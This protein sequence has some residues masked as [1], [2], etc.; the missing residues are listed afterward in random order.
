MA[1]VVKDRARK[2]VAQARKRALDTE[3]KSKAVALKKKGILTSKVDARK[4]ITRATRTKI[5]KFSDV[6][7]GRATAVRAPKQVREDYSEKGIYEQVAGFLK[8]PTPKPGTRVKLKKNKLGREYVQIIEPMKDRA[9]GLNT[10]DW[11]K[12]VLP[13]KPVDMTAFAEELRNNPTIDGLKEPDE[14]FTFQIDGWATEYNAVDGEEL[15]DILVNKYSHLFSESSNNS[16][17]KYMAL[18]RFKGNTG[19]MIPDHAHK[20]MA[21]KPGWGK[22]RDEDQYELQNV[23]LN[24][25]N[26]N[27][28]YQKNMTPE[29][30]A[31]GLETK[32]LAS[33]ARR[34]KNKAEKKGK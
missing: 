23:R 10:G 31:A 11:E 34:A 4:R 28:R 17:V 27:K 33:I 12:V 2:A 16:A 1:N 25:S 20:G 29:A 15:A 18:Y 21:K 19:F 14:M 3:Y 13:I 32:R 5:N 9:S 7:E 30:R 6:L 8:V 22:G 24:K 26:R